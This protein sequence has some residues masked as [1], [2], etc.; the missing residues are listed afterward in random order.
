MSNVLN[1][2]KVVLL[3]KFRSLIFLKI[4]LFIILRLLGDVIWDM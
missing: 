2:C 3:V 4:K 1:V